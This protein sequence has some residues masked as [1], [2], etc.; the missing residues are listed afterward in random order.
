[1]NKFGA[2]R[3]T[4]DGITYDSQKEAYRAQELKL[5]E[6]AGVISKLERQPTFILLPA[7]RHAGKSYR[8]VQFTP[9]FIYQ[10]NGRT[11][12]EDVKGISRGGR[13][14]TATDGYQLRKKLFLRLYGP[15]IDEF[16]EV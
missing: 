1:M 3:I 14:V 10:E 15:T 5:L 7:F 11:I 13:K 6:R 12:I 8:A 16:R 9:D 2:K 4:I